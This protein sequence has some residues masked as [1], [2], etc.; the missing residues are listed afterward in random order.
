MAF[1]ESVSRARELSDAL[2]TA[3]ALRILGELDLFAGNL[4]QAEGRIRESLTLYADFGSDLDRSACLIALGGVAAARG[5]RNEAA[6]LF[7]E[8]EALQG[9]APPEAPERAVLERFR[10]PHHVNRSSG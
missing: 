2:H 1:E 5:M 9:P 8:A 7:D 3:E 10:E 6:Q 4:D